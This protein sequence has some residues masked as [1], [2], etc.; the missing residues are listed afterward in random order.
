[1][2]LSF[3]NKERYKEI[4]ELSP[5][6][7][8]IINARGIITN[9]NG[10]VYDWLKYRPE[11]VI[12]KNVLEV[13]F[14]TDTGRTII[15]KNFSL[16]MQG[17]D[18]PPYEADFISKSNKIR[19]GRITAT[20]LKD[21]SNNITGEIIMISDTTDIKK[22]K[23][24]LKKDE[25]KLSEQNTELREKNIVLTE[26][27]RQLK[28]ERERAEEQIRVNLDRMILPLLEKIK[29]I[30]PRNNKIYISLLA[31]NLKNC[32]DSFGKKISVELKLAK[33]EI[34]ICNMIKNDIPSEEIAKLLKISKRTVELHRYNIRK[35]LGISNQKINL[36]S[37]LKS[38]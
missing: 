22:I 38:L 24:H 11:E 19:T 30:T 23:E 33:K 25:K 18:V 16:R 12:G 28:Q 15:R 21:N 13:P 35:K 10:R 37:Y 3:D 14:M 26:L 27:T 7:I 1:M 6:A 34:E 32:T 9:I 29:K 17:K 8:V 36:S 2:N 31:D 4:F 20:I 5:E